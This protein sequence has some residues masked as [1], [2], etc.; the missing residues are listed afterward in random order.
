MF[1]RFQPRMRGWV[2]TFSEWL[3]LVKSIHAYVENLKDLKYFPV[4]LNRFKT[5]QR[6]DIWINT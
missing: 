4:R 2:T 6:F 3:Y 5:L 1:T